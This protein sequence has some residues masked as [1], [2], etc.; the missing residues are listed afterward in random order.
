MLAS[1]E[2]ELCVDVFD[3]LAQLLEL[4]RGL[5]TN[6]GEALGVDLLLDR[7]L[8]GGVPLRLSVGDPPAQRRVDVRLEGV[9]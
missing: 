4:G 6:A 8:R 7:F 1:D 3:L 5:F 2:I 9:L